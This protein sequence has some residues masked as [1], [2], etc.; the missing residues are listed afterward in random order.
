MKP[1]QPLLK[2]MLA[3]G[4]ALGIVHAQDVLSGIDVTWNLVNEGAQKWAQK[5]AGQLVGDLNDT[6]RQVLSDKI[7]AWVESGESLDA[8]KAELSPWFGE[9]RAA[10]IASTEVTRSFS[11]ANRIAYSAAGIE[12][13]T[14]QTANDETVCPICGENDGE[15]FAL[16]DDDNT[17]PLHPG[18]RC[19]ISP[20]V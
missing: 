14:F 15:S 17:P 20:D 7:A 11:S 4:T 2:N 16:D 13:F 5:W 6:S 19:W 18:C 10:N 8:L 9:T 1:I 12:T 3:D